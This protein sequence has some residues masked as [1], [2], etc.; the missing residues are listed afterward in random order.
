MC[1][2][3]DPAATDAVAINATDTSGLT[4]SFPDASNVSQCLS[5]TNDVV[6][7]SITTVSEGFPTIVAANNFNSSASE[8]DGILHYKM[9]SQSE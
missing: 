8:C 4:E 5:T 6:T 9:L 2:W 3:I 1:F 7:V